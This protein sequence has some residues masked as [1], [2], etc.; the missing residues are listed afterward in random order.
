MWIFSK[1]STVVSTVLYSINLLKFSSLNRVSPVSTVK[2]AFLDLFLCSAV[3][4]SGRVSTDPLLYKY[5]GIEKYCTTV[6]TFSASLYSCDF[7]GESSTQKHTGLNQTH[8][9]HLKMMKNA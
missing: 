2:G 6:L 5:L 4:L 3:C 9:T 1:V 8:W 7:K